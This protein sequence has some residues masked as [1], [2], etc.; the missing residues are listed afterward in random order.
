MADPSQPV[1]PPPR[2]IRES[3]NASTSQHH[4]GEAIGR[5]TKKVYDI[6][7]LLSLRHVQGQVP[8]MLHVKP[9]AIAGDFT[10]PYN[11]SS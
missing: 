8:V 2:A 3:S 10:R 5:R 9:E 4:V 11:V 6:P 1:T 7:T